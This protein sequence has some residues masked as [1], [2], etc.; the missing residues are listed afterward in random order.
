MT[1]QHY[2]PDAIRAAVGFE[3]VI[4]PVSA[5]LVDFSAGLGDSPVTVFAPAGPDGDVHVKSAWLPGRGIFTVKV[6]TWFAERARRGSAAGAGIIAAFDAATGDLQALLEDEHHL[7]DIRTAATGALAART[8]ARPDAAVLGVLGTGTQAYLQVLAAAAERP[9]REVRV[10]GRR[11][12]R[13]SKLVA[14]LYRRR[15]DLRV[16]TVPDPR[17]ACAGVDLLVTATASTQPLVHGHWL[18]PGV[19]ITAVGADGPAKVELTAG[20]LQR[21]DR[22]VVDS[23]AL[24]AIYGDLAQAKL[25]ANDLDELGELLS[26]APSGRRHADEITICKLVGLGVQ[27]LAAAEVTL[28]RLRDNPRTGTRP[29]S[30]RDLQG[31]AS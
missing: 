11:P 3:D 4:E 30:A 6:A 16:A 20:C 24:A 25:G 28:A 21:A 31:D 2:G 1:L 7:S 23:R 17:S 29:A 15:P 14:A 19:H 13:A 5:A 10:W 22:L 8:L 26:G 9:V 18:T 12:H 27:D